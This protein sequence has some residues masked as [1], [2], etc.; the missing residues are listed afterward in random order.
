MLSMIVEG[1]ELNFLVDTGAT[2]S[3]LRTTPSSATL[4]D[5]TVSV[6]GFPGI[7]MTL[8]LSHSD[9]AGKTDFEAQI[10]DLSTSA[11]ESDEFLQM[12]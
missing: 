3:T 8:P 12:D 6:V 11:C 1:A 9:Q 2:Y 5:H 10:L 7:P 4:S